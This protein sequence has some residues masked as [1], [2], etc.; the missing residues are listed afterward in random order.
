MAN[1]FDHI[2]NIHF[3]P[4]CSPDVLNYKFYDPSRRVM[5]KTLEE[6]LKVSVCYWHNFCWDGS[7]PFGHATRKMPWRDED[8]QKEAINKANAVFEFIQKLGIKYFTF[9]DTDIIPP[10]Y[11]VDSYVSNFH[12][13]VDYL[14]KKMNN[15]DIKLLWGTANLFSDK[16]YLAGA[17][18]NPDPEIFAYA[19]M[20]TKHALEATHRLK[21][22]NYVIWGGR[23]GYDTLL[24][25]DLKHEK[26]MLAR[27]L[28]LVVEHKC[29]IGYK[30][31]LLIEPKPCEP[32]KHQYDYDTE[33]VYGFLCKYG[34]QNEFKVNIEANHATLANHS[35]EHEVYGACTL[36]VMGSIDAN[37]GDPHNGWDTDHFPNSIEE[38]TLVMYRILQY[39]GLSSGGFNFDCKVRRQSIN[40]DDMFYGHVSGIDVLS[41]ALLNAEKIINKG[42]IRTSVKK[43]YSGWEKGSGNNIISDYT[44]EKLSDYVTD[45]KINPKPV[46]G[47]QEKL[48]RII[49][50]TMY[51]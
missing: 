1:Y 3:E 16:R 27:F 34:L 13:L 4:N 28:S 51:E 32:T 23:E 24:N 17:A 7:D 40:L 35:F 37:R 22:D 42:L 39:G 31:Q 48:E 36:G 8:P 10:S 9:H 12:N 44:L 6:H 18:T 45:N 46:S 5:G 15:S 25:T 47:E 30:G 14:E 29:K 2:P 26:D 38:M 20:Q 49:I 50:N 33:S 21:G 11:S 19:A 43:R 41:K